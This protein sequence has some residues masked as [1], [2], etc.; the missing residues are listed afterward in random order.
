MMMMIFLTV[1]LL[2]N[3]ALPIFVLTQPTTK[4]MVY[5]LA[6][7]WPCSICNV[8]TCIPAHPPQ[9]VFT[10]HGLWPNNKRKPHV[11][12]PYNGPKNIS[13][14]RMLNASWPNVENSSDNLGFWK[15]EWDK[16]GIYSGLNQA[17]YFDLAMKLRQNVQVETHIKN[18]GIKLGAS[19]NIN[20][21]TVLTAA[22]KVD[23]V[24]KCNLDKNKNPQVWEVRICYDPIKKAL[25]S[26]STNA[27]DKCPSTYEIP[28]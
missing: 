10:L 9:Q 11:I 4:K 21:T 13:Q 6:L 19:N 23:V 1:I 5:T 25:M 28:L 8:K 7:Q 27:Q 20:M 24:V 26:C 22:L 15:Y 14:H 16:H 18:G 12:V 3:P 17:D 2:L